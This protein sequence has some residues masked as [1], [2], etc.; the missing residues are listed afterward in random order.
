M[1]DVYAIRLRYVNRTNESFTARM[2]LHAADGTL[3]KDTQVVFDP[4]LPHKWGLI[5]TDTGTSINA[6]NY[7]L[8]LISENASGLAIAGLEIQ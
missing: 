2:L 6:G 7:T 4:Y 8:T 5:H 1:A 3:M